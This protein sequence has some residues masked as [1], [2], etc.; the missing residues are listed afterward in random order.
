MTKLKSS[1]QD[2]PSTSAIIVFGLDENG[3]PK[4][5]RFPKQHATMARKAARSLKL[6]ACNVDRPSLVEIVAK[7]PTGRVHSTG[8]AFLPYIKQALYDELSAAARPARSKA[9]AATKVHP[10]KAMDP[11]RQ[12]KV[13]IVLG[14]DETLKPRGAKFQDPDEDRLIKLS[15]EAKLNLYELRTTASISLSESLPVGKLPLTGLLTL[16]EIRQSVYSEV[17]VDLADEPDAVPRGKIQSPL[18]EQKG[19]PENWDVIEPG[20]LVIAQESPEYGWA[21]AIVVG[22]KD[23]L[24]ALRYRDYPKLPQFFRPCRAVA[25][26]SRDTQ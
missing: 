21:E 12:R 6:V 26:L 16:P 18:P 8:R 25:L 15:T 24:L 7:I 22:R 11:K 5:G 19:S 14:F 2:A 13:F 3:K 4:A 10:T 17:I 1:K 9:A 20:H 23:G